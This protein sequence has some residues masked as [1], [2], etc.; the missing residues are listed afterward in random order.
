MVPGL[1]GEGEPFCPDCDR[2]LAPV[3][4]VAGIDVGTLELE[5]IRT[6]DLM[7]TDV[8]SAFRLPVREYWLGKLR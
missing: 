2:G 4:A 7:R 8:T 3:K 6:L 1:E 5:F